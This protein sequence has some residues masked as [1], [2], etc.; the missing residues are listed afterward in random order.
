MKS[1]L[2]FEIRRIPLQ[3]L[4]GKAG[5]LRRQIKDKIAT[6]AGVSPGVQKIII[7]N[8]KQNERLNQ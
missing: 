1:H 8:F 7:E 3:P 4:I 2:E 5:G 6:P